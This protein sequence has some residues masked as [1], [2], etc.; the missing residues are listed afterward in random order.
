MQF[1]NEL[2]PRPP[3]TGETVVALALYLIL[4]IMVIQI[5]IRPA[6]ML[7]LS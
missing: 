6:V 4:A 2:E 7:L 3:T 5:L 1:V